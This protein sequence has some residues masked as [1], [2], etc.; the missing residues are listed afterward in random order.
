LTETIAA[1]GGKLA[2]LTA[3]R[4]S[5]VVVRSDWDKSKVAL[6]AA[7]QATSL[8]IGFVGAGMLTPRCAVM[9]CIPCLLMPC[10]PVVLAVSP[11]GYLLIVKNYTGDRLNLALLLS[12]RARLRS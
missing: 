1:S 11:A 2:R 6:V 5:K 3:I 7:G 4:T 9:F 12:A 10:L 8:H